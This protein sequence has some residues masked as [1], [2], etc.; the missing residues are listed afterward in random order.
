MSAITFQK[1]I[2][3]RKWIRANYELLHND[4]AKLNVV[5]G[6]EELL[7]ISKACQDAI[8][9]GMPSSEVQGKI[10]KTTMDQFDL[11]IAGRPAS[12]TSPSKGSPPQSQAAPEAPKP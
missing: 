5:L 8:I 9:P 11:I 4:A 10:K 7:R 6:K 3:L 1:A 12:S 2:F